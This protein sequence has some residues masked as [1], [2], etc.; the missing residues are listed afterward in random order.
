[1]DFMIFFYVFFGLMVFITLAGCCSGPRRA[2]KTSISREPKPGTRLAYYCSRHTCNGPQ[3]RRSCRNCSANNADQVIC[4]HVVP[5]SG[6][7]CEGHSVNSN[8][9]PPSSHDQAHSHSSSSPPNYDAGD[10]NCEARDC[11]CSSS[12]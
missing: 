3:C 7:C 8:G 2:N 1:M 12:H 5:S 6:R 10:S 4:I 11:G 9:L